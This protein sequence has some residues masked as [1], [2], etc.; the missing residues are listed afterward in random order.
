MRFIITFLII[1][2]TLFTAISQ[3]NENNYTKIDSLSRK[4][5]LNLLSKGI[6]YYLILN[7]YG[8]DKQISSSTLIWREGK[9]HFIE[10]TKVS[11]KGEINKSEKNIKSGSVFTDINHFLS[12]TITT[13]TP[14]T[15]SYASHFS[16]SIKL[17]KKKYQDVFDA[18]FIGKETSYSTTEIF[19]L[20]ERYLKQYKFIK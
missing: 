4:S 10:Y 11:E 2:C 17:K 13:P 20:V 9:A 1:Y 3:T 7:A 8:K 16:L 6:E 5:E 18:G 19:K 15:V 12:D 14:I